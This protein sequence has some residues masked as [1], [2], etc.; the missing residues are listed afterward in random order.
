MV[1]NKVLVLIE[2]KD[3]LNEYFRQ[4]DKYEDFEHIIC[5]LTPY[6]VKY[7]E[8][9]KLNY[10]EPISCYSPNEY[11]RHKEVSEKSIKELVAIINEC[12][13]HGNN[14]SE[15]QFELGNYFHFQLYVIIG[16]YHLKAFILDRLI[17]KVKPKRITCFR[18]IND[19]PFLG[20]RPNPDSGN[21]F[22]DL[23]T[24]S[25][26]NSMTIHLSYQKNDDSEKREE[27]T[28]T[29]IKRTLFRLAGYIPLVDR[30]YHHILLVKKNMT[31]FLGGN[32]RLKKEKKILIIGGIY[33]WRYVF[34]N[35]KSR[36]KHFLISHYNKNGIFDFEND[37]TPISKIKWN[38][39]FASFRIDRL[40]EPI[41]DYIGQ[42]LILLKI[43]HDKYVKMVRKHDVSVFSVSPY[44]IHAYLLHLSKY[45]KKKTVC[46]Q[47]GIQNV[48]CDSLFSEITELQYCDY[49]LAFGENV[50]EK[51]K[52]YEGKG[53]KRTI[54]V[55]SASIDTFCADTLHKEKKRHILYATS[56]YLLNATP[57]IDD[58]GTDQ[59]LFDSQVKILKYLDSDAPELKEWVKILKPNN[60][61][62]HG[63]LDFEL[64]N[65]E[66][67][68]QFTPFTSLLN[69]AAIII[70]DRPAT[71][72]LEASAVTEVP[73]F[74]VMNKS[75]FPIARE[76]LERRAVVSD[77][78]EELIGKLSDYL[79]TGKYPADVA[80]RDFVKAYAT[81]LD[82]GCSAERALDFLISICDITPT[83]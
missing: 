8:E 42:Y 51:Y 35:P 11:Y 44:P 33:N 82:D 74:V 3:Q 81:H 37:E 56:K 78:P 61:L 9:N 60:T 49:Y 30:L 32:I 48:Y 69:S 10:I 57:L 17:N 31:P 23:L 38:G 19:K 65:I 34:S 71:T 55:G 72:A 7:C 29:C 54:A 63:Y 18:A 67:T 64:N 40:I 59:K 4:K 14:K 20:F 6:G 1:K 77:T 45:L 16:S 22:S 53:L 76:F 50:I 13:K 2:N 66:I 70:L 5:A 62:I 68:N 39:A 15:F 75:W 25:P 47:H 83:S 41:L 80:N 27:G 46:Y 58:I 52:K 21:M 12:Y 79:R 24:H 36:K 26:Y 73:I 28:R 43:K